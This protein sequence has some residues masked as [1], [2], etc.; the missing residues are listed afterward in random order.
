MKQKGK[1]Y[2][3]I[4][5]HPVNPGATWNSYFRIPS[6]RR[7]M[8]LDAIYF[9]IMFRDM[10]T[11]ELFTENQ[12]T[13]QRIQLGIVPIPASSNIMEVTGG[14]AFFDQGNLNLFASANLQ[15]KG[16]YFQNNIPMVINGWNNDV[17]LFHHL[18]S[19][20]LQVTEY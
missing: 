14:A 10:V 13:T 7:E 3:A 6:F 8:S 9:K 15:L 20:T 12:N 5:Q 16:M 11:N 18:V 19:I 4:W 2:S 17:N 1:I